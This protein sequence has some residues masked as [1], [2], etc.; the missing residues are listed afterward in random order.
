MNLEGAI[1]S[2]LRHTVIYLLGLLSISCNPPHIS[3]LP[4][5]I[6]SGKTLETG[7]AVP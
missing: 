6:Q 4:F 3:A 7:L 2:K 1:V 5:L